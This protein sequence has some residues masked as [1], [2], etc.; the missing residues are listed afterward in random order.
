M[1]VVCVFHN[2]SVVL[3]FL[4]NEVRLLLVGGKKE[5]VRVG[6]LILVLLL[7][8]HPPAIHLSITNW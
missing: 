3:P 2:G 5:R 4:R 1:G 6:V 7:S 8:P